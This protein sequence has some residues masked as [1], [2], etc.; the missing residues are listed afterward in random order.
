MIFKSKYKKENKIGKGLNGIV[1]KVL[2]KTENKHYALKIIDEI[3]NYK[4]EI[5][6]MKNIKSKYIIQLKDY[7]YEEKV[8]Y[9]IVMELCDGDLR[10]LLNKYKPKGLPLNIINKIF[11]QLNDALK[12]MIDI[13]YI[14]RD[15]KPENILIKYTD[16]N[17]DNFDIRLT[18]FGLS[19]NEINYSIDCHTITG[20]L[21]YM[22]PEIETGKYN[23]KCDLWSLGVILYELYTN[24]YMFDSDN[25]IKTEMNKYQGKII[26]E[27]DN[28]MINKLI[29]KLI[30]VDIHKRIKW[31]EYFNDDFFKIDNEIN[32][33]ENINIE[34]III[35]NIYNN[36]NDKN[37]NIEINNDN[38]ENEQIIKIKIE[39]NEDNEEIK[40]YN[41][42]EDINEENIQLFIDNEE[43][44]FNKEINDLKKG[45]Y[46][47]IIKINQ[48]ITNC[49]EMFK[50]CFNI[51][52]I[53]FIKFET[54]NVTNMSRVFCNCKSL[55]NI[56][57][58][59][60]DTKNVTDMSGIF[61]YCFSLNNL[62]LSNFDTKNVNNMS[63]MFN[64]CLSLNNLNLSNFDTKNVTNMSFM[65]SHCES[66]KNL[67]VTN[68]DTKNVTDMSRMFY[69][70]KSLKN[71][72]VN[73]FE[74]KNV[75]SMRWM[76][77]NC[78][79]LKNLNITNFETKNVTD[80]SEMFSNCASLKSLNLSNF[81]TKK[82]TDMS[83]MFYNCKSLK[84]L[85]VTNFDTKNVIDMSDMFY[86]CASLKNLNVTNFDTKN[87][88]N[89]SGMF[90]DCKSLKKI[91][92]TYFDTKNVTD[93][94][95]MFCNCKS[96]KNLNVNNF[97]IKNVTDKK[98]VLSK[99]ASLK[100]L[101]I[102][103]YDNK[104]VIYL[105]ELMI[106][107]EKLTEIISALN[108]NKFIS[109]KCFEYWTY[110]YNCTLLGKLEKLFLNK[111][112]SL[113][114]TYSIKYKLLTILLCYDISYDFSLLSKVFMLIKSILYLN[115]K[116]LLIISEYIYPKVSKKTMNNTWIYKLRKLINSQKLYD[117]NKEF[118]K[119]KD[120]IL[121]TIENLKSNTN[122]ISSNINILFK[123]YLLNSCTYN[124]NK[125]ELI[126]IH[127]NINDMNYEDF[128]KFFQVKILHVDN[129]NISSFDSNI[130]KENFLNIIPPYLT[131]INKKNFTLVLD[132]E[133]TLV[134]F[135]VDSNN[136]KGL[137]L[138][139]PG[140]FEFLETLGNY[141]E[142]IIF[143]DAAQDYVDLLI[144]I[145]ENNKIYFDYRLYRQHTILI[146]NEYVKDLT[147]IGR[148]INK[149]IIVD[150]IP[151]NFRLQK[152]NGIN[153]KSFW[154]D[155]PYDTALIDLMPILVN[156]AKE[157][158]DVRDGLRKYRYE[159]ENKITK[160]LN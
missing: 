46:N 5:E 110:F 150:N 76:F 111:T 48:K 10:Q 54:K 4:K 108:T 32:N 154:G 39:V 125:N 16:N 106:L 36:N 71:L 1:Y 33:N 27:T 34:N 24:K 134:Y 8:G 29:R 61:S 77:Y 119:N 155:D 114:I 75:I 105:E 7:F 144:N 69:Y 89:M 118:N 132:F 81:D 2:D 38:N 18:D 131:N 82:V 128:N 23:N 28:E 63:F 145:I 52:E 40:I 112:D 123:Q 9:C 136:D 96:L 147:R 141:Y 121:T 60:F 67:D 95:G 20:S 103:N 37:I 25:P 15:L 130:L 158:G 66:L 41:G 14:H 87:V 113:I 93:M 13:D 97:E 85:D 6:V 124:N 99:C 86:N 21:Y 104:N 102:P 47:I 50:N 51:I 43:I 151:Q 117:N 62:N 109:N 90:E 156:I 152:E 100:N 148:P 135:L 56:N 88:T 72:I 101:D 98:E 153:I 149:I 127:K 79:S 30:K 143:T 53:R 116:N 55:K 140:I 57:I 139:R 11:I 146:D 107:V 65:F 68:F 157:G 160:L 137:L 91:N 12:A 22:A 45:I 159:I 35:K 17:K 80:M 120:Q 64:F 74:T 126:N 31:E 129:R 70:C 49:K 42:N 44:E 84:N 59:N 138:F 92:V 133:E 26:D 122:L 73:N 19:K 3:E 83:D 94:N 115:Y 58:T 142:I 78:K